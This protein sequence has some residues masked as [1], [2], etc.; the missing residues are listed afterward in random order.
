MLVAA[1][2]DHESAE[3]VK[4]LAGLAPGN[5][6]VRLYSGGRHGVDLFNEDDLI[7][8]IIQWLRTYLS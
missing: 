7:P 1:Q 3:G 8:T 6:M 5:T 2:I 4:K